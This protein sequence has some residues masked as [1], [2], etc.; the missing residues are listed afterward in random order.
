MLFI[1]YKMNA[2]QLMWLDSVAVVCAVLYSLS[3]LSAAVRNYYNVNDFP[4]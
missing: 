3:S 4:L 2:F 1:S